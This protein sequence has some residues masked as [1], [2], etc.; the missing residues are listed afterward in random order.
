MLTLLSVAFF[1]GTIRIKRLRKEN[2]NS[3]LEDLP[4]E[5]V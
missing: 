1:L 5:M 3:Y 2:G 4:Y